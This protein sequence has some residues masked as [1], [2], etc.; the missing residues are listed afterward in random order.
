MIENS[1]Q[2]RMASARWVAGLLGALKIWVQGMGWVLAGSLFQLML[3][4][5]FSVSV[6]ILRASWILLAG[7]FAVF[8]FKSYRRL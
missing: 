6:E 5:L 8:I 1:F 7:T 4:A 2:R 3:T